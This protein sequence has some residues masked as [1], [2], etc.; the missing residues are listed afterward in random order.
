MTLKTYHLV[1]KAGHR[2]AGKQDGVCS[3]ATQE[4][5]A[6]KT[7]VQDFQARLGSIHSKTLPQETEGEGELAQ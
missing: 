7:R 3:P 1:E 6:E 2:Q 4:D 5:D